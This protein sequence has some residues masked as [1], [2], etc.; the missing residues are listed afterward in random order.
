MST[1]SHP[2]IDSL[3]GSMAQVFGRT[4]ARPAHTPPSTP[5]QRLYIRTM[6][7]QLDLDTCHITRFHRRHFAAAQLPQ[8]E[9]GASIDAVLCGLDRAQAI[10][11]IN[12]LK[13]EVP[14]DG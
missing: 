1:P 7:A 11:L 3:V 13:P 6:F 14:T 10:A 9:A 12:A 5:Y 8:P 4:P 2:I